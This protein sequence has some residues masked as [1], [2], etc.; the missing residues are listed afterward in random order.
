MTSIVLAWKAAL[1]WLCS[2]GEM[3]SPAST[4]PVVGSNPGPLA[5]LGK[6]SAKCATSP[7][8]GILIYHALC[9]RCKP[10]YLYLLHGST[11]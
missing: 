11:S 4:S 7:A 8:R 6:H 3:S 9:R 10:A 2:Q 1:N 5:L